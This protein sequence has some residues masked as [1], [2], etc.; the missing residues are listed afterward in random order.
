MVYRLY[1][2]EN[3]AEIVAQTE[4]G[5]DFEAEKWARQWAADHGKSDDYRIERDGGGFSA[6]LF[7]TIGDQWYVMRQ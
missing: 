7:K 3:P 5:D 6:R 1:E 4:C 2:N